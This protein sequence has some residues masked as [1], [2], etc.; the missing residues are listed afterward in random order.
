MVDH[1]EFMC[2]GMSGYETID[3]P[4]V[5]GE[6][7]RFYVPCVDVVFRDNVVVGRPDR[8]YLFQHYYRWRVEWG[9]NVWVKDGFDPPSVDDVVLPGNTTVMRRPDDRATRERPTG[10]RLGPPRARGRLGPST[11]ADGVASLHVQRTDDSPS[12]GDARVA[13]ALLRGPDR[14]GVR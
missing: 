1:G 14:A 5:P 7:D 10:Q 2:Q 6:D 8:K 3:Y 11:R 13:G 9:G 4:P 12:A